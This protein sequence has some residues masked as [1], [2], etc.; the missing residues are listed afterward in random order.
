MKRLLANLPVK[1][2]LLAITLMFSATLLGVVIYTVITLQQQQA[3]STVLNIAGRQRMLTQKFTKELFDEIIH[4]KAKSQNIDSSKTQKL[5]ELSLKALR[6]GG[7]TYADLAMNTPVVLPPNSDTDIDASLQQVGLLWSKLQAAALKAVQADS[8]SVV[9]KENVAAIRNLNLEVLSAMDAAVSMF[10]DVST[11]KID[12]MIKAEWGILAIILPFG[13]WFCLYIVSTITKPLALIVD[14]TKRIAAGDMSVDSELQEIDSKDELG[15]LSESYREMISV[16]NKMQME[17]I[18]AANSA[19]EGQLDAL[20]DSKEYEGVRGEL[21]EG[22]NEI[23]RAYVVP[24]RGTA[25]YL[26]RISRGDIPPLVEKEYKGSFNDVKESFN[27]SITTINNLL[28]E[29]RLLI[30]AA[31]NGELEVRG[32]LDK[33]EGKWR[34]LID[35]LNGVFE[36]VV[37]PVRTA[38]EVLRAISDGD[39]RNTMG[40]DYKGE[41]ATLCSNVNTTIKRLE[42]TVIPVQEAADF[43]S[44]SASEIYAGNNDL[45]LRTDKQSGSLQET[46][47]SMEQLIGT[48]R[49]NADNAKQANKLAASARQSAEHGGDVVSRAVQA[50]DEINRSSNKISEIISVIDEIAFQTNLLALN[51]S[52]EAA[53]AGEQGRGFAV[54][55]TEVRNLAG[56]SATAAKEIKELIQ[57]SMNK[58]QAGAAL[59]NES[60]VTLDDI[61]DGVK[62]VGDII[63]EIDA[64]SAEQTTGIEQVNSAITSMDEMVQQNAVLAERTSIASGSMRDRAKEL[65]RLMQFFKVNREMVLADKQEPVTQTVTISEPVVTDDVAADKQVTEDPKR[66]DSNINQFVVARQYAEESDEWEEF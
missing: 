48:V 59:V 8:N 47:S 7:E 24:F 4:G 11:R 37:D 9:Y 17:I 1:S 45:S 63:S 36:A 64:A 5:F 30:D 12:S 53:R 50:M 35:G 46:A 39:L 40:G 21:L 65:E 3:D 23:I 25:E 62:K 15:E 32:D 60:G 34:E 51:A 58:V 31:H 14:A 6:N 61:M 16:I 29:S 49:N 42:A 55:A 52:V 56:R 33:F 54:V 10:A 19:K 18:K 2:K 28:L 41:Y 66:Q 22:I 20:C 26:D 44:R 43:I 57:D 13:I 27:L 38:G